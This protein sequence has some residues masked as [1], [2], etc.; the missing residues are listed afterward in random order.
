[1]IN[2]SIADPSKW[3][4]YI[5]KPNLILIIAT[6]FYIYMLPVISEM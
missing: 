5:L 6:N 1:M 3:T 4:L 2:L